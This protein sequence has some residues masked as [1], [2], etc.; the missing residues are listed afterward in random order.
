MMLSALMLLVSIAQPAVELADV[1]ERDVRAIHRVP[2]E[3]PYFPASA[4]ATAICTGVFDTNASG[5]PINMC[6]R[7]ATRVEMALSEPAR[8]L[9]AAQFVQASEVALDQWRYGEPHLGRQGMSATL[10]YH[11]ADQTEDDLPEH[12]E[13]GECLGPYIS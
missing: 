11:L 5:R 3:Y 12:P 2:P 13:L 4:G 10:V 1:I 9:V 8:E 7:C 6:M